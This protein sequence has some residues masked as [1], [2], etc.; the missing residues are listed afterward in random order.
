MNLIE[1]ESL[2]LVVITGFVSFALSKL[3]PN[4]RAVAHPDHEERLR[5]SVV[6]GAFSIGNVELL[7]NHGDV[8]FTHELSEV[9]AEA[10]ARATTERQVSIG[11]SLLS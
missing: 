6:R 7:I 8:S 1:L 5:I 3:K 4:W 11:V 10:D 9:L 2:N